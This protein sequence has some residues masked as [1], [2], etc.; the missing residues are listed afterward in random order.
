M[1]LGVDLSRI[2]V[3]ATLLGLVLMNV[4]FTGMALLAG[5]VVLVIKRGNPL[6]WA[7]RGASVVLG[8]ILYPVEVL[9]PA[10]QT[11]GVLLPITHALTVLRGAM[12]EGQGITELAIPLAALSVVSATYLVLGLAASAAAVRHARSDGSLAQY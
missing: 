9:P 12:L 8:G 5:A 4:G 6:G 2:D 11:L 1:A 10:L 7:L 3:P